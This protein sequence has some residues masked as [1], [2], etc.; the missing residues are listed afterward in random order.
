MKLEQEL[1]SLTAVEQE[2]QQFKNSNSDI[3]KT[4]ELQI[5][6]AK[7]L[8]EKVLSL[9]QSNADYH[10]EIQKLI[11]LKDVNDSIT[12]STAKLNEKIKSVVDQYESEKSKCKSLEDDLRKANYD[13]DTM[14]T[15]LSA[16]EERNAKLD[17][18]LETIITT[19]NALLND[20]NLKHDEILSLRKRCEV[21]ESKHKNASSRVV[22][23]EASLVEL[24][25]EF[26]S[27][28]EKD[29]N[30]F[31]STLQEYET[32]LESTAVDR[33]S[34]I[35]SLNEVTKERDESLALQSALS[36]LTE[37]MEYKINQLE[38]DK[39]YSYFHLLS[40]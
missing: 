1:M 25:T 27:L 37:E 31:H 38:H 18:Q 20:N 4:L 14:S 39:R 16:M 33:E 32:R 2:Y 9:Q 30:K 36:Q 3:S 12:K 29:C 13:H 10:D 26:R 15:L 28:T 34:L 35:A 11:K 21:I 22:A 6:K 5:S 24:S 40:Y 23:L 19:N 17:K 8:E 7:A